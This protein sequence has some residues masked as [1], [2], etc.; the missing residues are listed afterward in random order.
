[1]TKLLTIVLFVLA[2]V[3]SASSSAN[4]TLV[5]LLVQSHG[6]SEQ[7]QELAL[8]VYASFKEVADAA[9]SSKGGLKDYF[10]TVAES[11][12]LD[13]AAAFEAY[14]QWQLNIDGKVLQLLEAMSQLHAELSVEQRQALLQ[15]L[16]QANAKAE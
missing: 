16:L 3:T 14:K 10:A 8:D 12:Q 2:T 1:M 6:F 9:K 13:A 5:K 11:D 7:Q 4:E 15:K